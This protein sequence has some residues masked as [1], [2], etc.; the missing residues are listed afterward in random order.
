[1]NSAFPDQSDA[2]SAGVAE[3]R[4][5]LY[6]L[7]GDLPARH[8]EITA[9][10]LAVEERAGYVLETLRLDLNGLEAVPAYFIR[11]CHASMPMPAVL[12][13]HA[14]GGNYSIGK[15]ELIHGR[16]IL[17]RP[18]YADFLAAEGICALCID[19][20]CFGERATRSESDTF[21]LMLWQGRVLWGMMVY[22]ALR[23]ADYLRTR[24][25]V[26][27]GRIATCGMSMG[28]S[29]SQWLTALDPGICAC[30]DICCLC[31]YQALIEAGG[32]SEHGIY[33]YVPS[34]LKHFTAA[35][36]NALIAP[37]PHLS[38]AGEFDPLTPVAGLDRIDAE[39]QQ[40]YAR[41]G[42]PERWKLVRYPVEHQETPEMRE[43]VQAFLRKY[44]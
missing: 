17:S 36:I 7:L 4:H 22:D 43:Q 14:H 16:G 19:A 23:A 38:L 5:E 35:Q 20:W 42:Q 9:E 10:T 30:V 27:A 28:S 31:D 21:K 33:Y 8:R 24:P 6:R 32:L 25:E 15:R 18:P 26:D 11:P 41:H 12:Y 1:M 3:R 37:R 13:Q 29:M 34:L 39:L 2:T 44:L 40:I